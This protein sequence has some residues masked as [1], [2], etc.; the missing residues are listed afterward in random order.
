MR[1]PLVIEFT[2]SP[3]SGKTSCIHSIK[4]S[5]EEMG[6]KVDVKQEDAELVPK[7]VPKKTWVRNMW[8]AAGQIQSLIE[9]MF[10][11]G[12]VVLLDR[13]YYDALFWA[14]FLYKEGICY[15]DEAKMLTDFFNSLEISF[16]L[17]P[18]L[19]V[20][21]YVSTEE[22][23][24]RRYAE[25]G[26]DKPVLS[27]NDFLDNYN[28]ALNEFCKPLDVLTYQIDTTGLTKEK[29]ASNILS[30]ILDTCD[31]EKHELR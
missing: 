10:F 25:E 7:C 1:K 23:L 20:V 29:I 28:K 19:L 22:G 30:V 8:I 31:F 5:L 17:R 24:R 13:G 3:N 26:S 11:D 16:A 12:D 2:G 15:Q 18:D 9:A 4:S 27:T 6:F 21:T 14:N